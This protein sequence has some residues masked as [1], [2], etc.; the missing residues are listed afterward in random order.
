M[1]G[2]LVDT[3]YQFHNPH[4]FTDGYDKFTFYPMDNPVPVSGIIHVGLI[5]QNIDRLNIGLDK[6][7]NANAGNLHYMLGPSADWAAS[8]ISGSV[9]IRPVLRAGKDY[10]S[11]IEELESGDAISFNSEVFPNPASSA[12]TLR[13]G[14]TS[15]WS[16]YSMS[17]K[18]V[19][20]GSMSGLSETI[21]IADLDA[22]IYLVRSVGH[23]A[24]T[25]KTHKLLIQK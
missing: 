16:I 11:A 13:C 9:M 7:T 25:V 18:L 22:G 10:T 5:Q 17:G 20:S 3:M 1:P 21:D 15:D 19:N 2:E 23:T 12:I 8:G 14:E 24:G 6:T 4:Y